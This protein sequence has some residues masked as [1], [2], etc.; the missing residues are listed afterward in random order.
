MLVML[1]VPWVI[2]IPVVHHRKHLLYT[3]CTNPIPLFKHVGS[4]FSHP[5]GEVLEQ[6]LSLEQNT[7]LGGLMWAGGREQ[8]PIHFG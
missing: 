8:P 1:K 4:T 6:L 5:A 7:C 3:V 2:D